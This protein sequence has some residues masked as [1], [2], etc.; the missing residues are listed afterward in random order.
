MVLTPLVVSI[1]SMACGA[2]QAPAGRQ[3]AT[4]NH[5]ICSAGRTA[6]KAGQW[7]S[8]CWRPYARS[9]PFNRPIPKRPRLDP[10]S[11]QIVDRL[12][13]FG[14]PNPLRAGV[15]DTDD[16]YYHPTYYATSSDPEYTIRGGS[17]TQPY[18][19]DGRKVRLPS[20]AR[21]ARGSDHHLTIV[22]EGYEYGL[23]DASVNGRNIDVGSGRKIKIAGRGIMGAATAARFGGLAGII[24]APEMESGRIRHA[25]FMTVQCTDGR[26]VYP[27]SLVSDDECDD[28]TDA[29]P[30][31]AH[32]QLHMSASNIRSLRAPRW[33][34]T[35]LTAMARYGMYVG[36]VTGSPWALQFESGSTYTSFGYED[37]MVTFAKRAHVPQRD[38]RYVFDF[39]SGVDWGR[40]LRVVAP[41]PGR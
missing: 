11:R 4:F 30:M 27:A 1:V 2:E 22:Y 40:Y 31:G 13:G 41:H 37:R 36:D 9:S 6:F 10:R 17:S 24:R 5:Q 18:A 25:L 8:A 16:D 32:F 39:A 29:P 33:K 21:P 23:W 28:P 14:R 12:V 19:V 26:A 3:V 20:G 34:K 35:I 15:A 7:P 38:G